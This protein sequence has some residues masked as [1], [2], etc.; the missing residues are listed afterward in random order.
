[1]K[2]M[3][4]MKN[5]RRVF[6]G[7]AALCVVGTSVAQTLYYDR[8]SFL[9][10]SR[11]FGTTT[12]DFD[13]FTA[14]TDLTGQTILG[15]T[16]TST[17]TNSLIVIAGSTGVRFPMSPSSGLNVLSPGGSDTSLEDD[18]LVVS[19]T[20]PMRAAGLDVVFDVPDGA[21]FVGVSFYALSDVLIAQDTF[22]PA[23]N[24]APGYQFV[25]LVNDTALISKIVVSEFD[26]SPSDDHVAYDSLV[27]LAVPEPATVLTLALGVA[28]LIFAAHRKKQAARS[29]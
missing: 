18:G 9:T 29:A 7:I 25:G 5:I 20:V 10:D 14:G 3:I 27:F 24:G 16:L 8:A 19:F 2:A 22:I 12:I 17:G 11:V 4:R 26:G 1:M 28:A 13:G 15:A 6:L 21:S 23:P